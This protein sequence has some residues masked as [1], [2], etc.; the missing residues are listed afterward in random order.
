M[1]LSQFVFMIKRLRT[2][3]ILYT[4]SGAYGF[5]FYITDTDPEKLEKQELQQP[6]AL[7]LSYVFR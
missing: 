2:N 6:N 5:V 7:A 1:K 3:L 4:L